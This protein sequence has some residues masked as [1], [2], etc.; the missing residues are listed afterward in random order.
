ML[1]LLNVGIAEGSDLLSPHA[2]QSAGGLLVVD[3]TLTTLDTIGKR[4]LKR[5]RADCAGPTLSPGTQDPSPNDV[6]HMKL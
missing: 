4:S 6:L 5:K 1:T 2:C 3:L